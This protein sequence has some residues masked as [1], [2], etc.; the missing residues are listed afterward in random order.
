MTLSKI[1]KITLL[2]IIKIT[3]SNNNKDNNIKTIMKITLLKSNKIL[4]L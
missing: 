3:W 1:I 2:K 4:V